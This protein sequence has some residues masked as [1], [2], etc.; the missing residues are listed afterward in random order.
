MAGSH[1]LD[2]SLPT[3]QVA[4]IQSKAELPSHWPCLI[5]GF[6]RGKQL[7]T[8]WSECLLHKRTWDNSLL[9]ILIFRSGT[10]N[11][12]ICSSSFSHLKFSVWQAF[13][14]TKYGTFR[15]LHRENQSFLTT[16][17]GAVPL[18]SS[19]NGLL[20]YVP[21]ADRIG[22]F[23]QG[24]SP[25]CEWGWR[26]K[27]KGSGCDREAGR[28]VQTEILPNKAYFLNHTTCPTR[29]T[30]LE[31]QQRGKQTEAPSYWC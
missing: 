3:P 24:P 5:T 16:L 19:T 23:L 13:P 17:G 15:V 9:N 2:K 8:F 14:F 28:P 30:V 20:F 12:H 11:S 29:F 27:D 18:L 4:G 22:M 7:D 31:I 26:W 6:L 1:P 25:I 21:R 10:I